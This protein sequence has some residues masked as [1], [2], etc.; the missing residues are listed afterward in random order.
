MEDFSHYATNVE[1]QRW[2]ALWTG[3]QLNDLV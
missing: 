1:Q 3:H 2:T